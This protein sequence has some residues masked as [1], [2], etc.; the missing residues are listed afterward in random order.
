MKIRLARAMSITSEGMVGLSG[1]PPPWHGF[2]AES[3]EWAFLMARWGVLSGTRA[4]LPRVSGRRPTDAHACRH[5]GR[6][7]RRDRR[8]GG[9]PCPPMGAGTGGVPT[10][11]IVVGAGLCARPC[12]PSPR[13][14][15]RRD[16]MVIPRNI[17]RGVARANRRQLPCVPRSSP[18][19]PQELCVPGFALAQKRD[20]AQP[21][22]G[23]LPERSRSHQPELGCRII[24]KNP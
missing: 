7:G 17:Q 5:R 2:A 14:P 18:L 16:R 3:T 20:H 11:V 15:D 10:G 12:V 22:S 9:P 6:P 4:R 24:L 19:L 13:G 23:H 21:R 1:S 8:R